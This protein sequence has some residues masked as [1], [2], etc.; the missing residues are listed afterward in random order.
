ME[1]AIP[2]KSFTG[3]IPGQLPAL[4]SHL[5]TKKRLDNHCNAQLDTYTAVMVGHIDYN[6]NTFTMTIRLID[7]EVEIF[8]PL[9]THCLRILE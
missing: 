2:R 8:L 6:A 5:F 3:Q 9:L 7:T 4:I 1:E